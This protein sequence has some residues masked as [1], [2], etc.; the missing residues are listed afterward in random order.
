MLRMIR[1]AATTLT[2]G[3]WLGRNRFWKIQIGR[4]WMPWPA[5]NVVTMISSK[6]SANDSRPPAS[7][8]ERSIGSVTCR[9][10]RNVPAPRSIEAS[11]RLPPSRRSRA[12]ALLNTVTMQNVACDTISVKKPS[13]MPIIV[14]KTFASAMPVTM[15]GSAIGRMISS[16]TE[17]RPKNRNRC[18]A[19][20]AMVPSTSA[21]SVATIAT[22]TETHTASRA[23]SRVEGRRPTT[24]S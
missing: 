4:V 20:A 21:T 18:S 19:R 5:V 12:T 17:S 22:C 14:V 8:A 23:P 1:A 16:E 13:L 6:L 3:A 2:T 24:R 11:S 10:V 7:S 15:P 9:N